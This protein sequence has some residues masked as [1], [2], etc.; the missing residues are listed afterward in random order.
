MTPH[1]RPT[2]AKFQPNPLGAAAAAA[3]VLVNDLHS[4]LNPTAV[5][6]IVRPATAAALPALIAEARREGVKLCTAGGWHAMGGQQFAHDALLLDTRDLAHVVAFHAD[7]GLLEVEAGIMWPAL[8]AWLRAAN[9]GAPR[10][11]AIR[12]KQSGADRLSIGGAVSANAHGRGLAMAPFVGDVEAITLVGADGLVRRCS[13]TEHDDLFRLAVGG[14]GLFGVIATVMLRLAPLTKL[15]RI[16]VEMDV[17]ELLPAFEQRIA[18]GY[19]YGDFQFAIDAASDSFLRR[20]LLS[21]YKPVPADTP[22]PTGQRS[23]SLADWN[24]LLYLTHTDKAEAY[25]RYVRHYLATS[26][27]LY[28][29]DTHQL[30]TYVDDYHPELDRRLGA[31]CPGSEMIS[32]LYVPRPLLTAFLTDARALLRELRADVVYGTIRLIERDE[33]SF[34]AWAREPWACTIFNVHVDHS[35][36]GIARAAEAFRGLIEIARTRGGSYFPTYHRWATRDQVQACHPRL[37][38]LLRLKRHHDPDELFQSTWYQHYA[39]MFASA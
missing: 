7:R 15:R 10:A 16:V 9:E 8:I 6:R 39:A 33:E 24:E 21:T 27:Q 20:G 38:E 14:Y 31:A 22:I 2:A 19:L 36:D 32:E 5:R 29:S 26:G 1:A 23:L 34:L 37:P 17:A 18:D 35:P 3:G 12:Q 30:A 25:A 28:W 4:C 11:W 13:R